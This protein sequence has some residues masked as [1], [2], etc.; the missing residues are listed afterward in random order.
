[1]AQFTRLAAAIAAASLAGAVQAGTMKTG[2]V[3]V[4]FG[5]EVDF[6]FEYHD[7]DNTNS[8]S[9][10]YLDTAEFSVE[11]TDGKTTAGFTAEFGTKSGADNARGNSKGGGDEFG[12]DNAFLEYKINDNYTAFAE[13]DDTQIGLQGKSIMWNDSMHKDAVYDY[14]DTMTGVK[15]A[16]GP[17]SSTIYLAQG[18]SGDDDLQEFGTSVDYSHDMFNA[19]FGYVSDAIANVGSPVGAFSFG[20]DAT[21]NNIT[22]IAEYV[23][24][25]DEVNNEDP[26]F[27]Q[28]EAN[29]EMKGYTFG[30][31]YMTSDEA[32]ALNS[33][34]DRIALTVIKDITDI[35]WVQAELD[36]D[37]AYSDDDDNSLWLVAGASF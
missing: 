19:H 3:E 35:L 9:D 31:A 36:F 25:S 28:L 34:E 23:F 33:T 17:I 32:E 24:L 8:S 5:G 11:A 14:T 6:A 37:S 22:L 1:M 10:V 20:A 27:L 16:G 13:Y 18:R 2:D 4:T 21:I 30:A 26:T 12:I 7:N 15:I 29:Y